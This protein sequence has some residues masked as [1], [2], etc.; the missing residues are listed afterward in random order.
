MTSSILT[1]KHGFLWRM[2]NSPLPQNNL[3]AK[4]NTLI[5]FLRP[6]S[7]IQA[8]NLIYSD[9]SSLDGCRAFWFTSRLMINSCLFICLMLNAW[10]PTWVTNNIHWDSTTFIRDE[11]VERWLNCVIEHWE[12]KMWLTL[13]DLIKTAAS[14][15]SLCRWKYVL[16]KFYPHS[17]LLC[18]LVHVAKDSLMGSELLP[19]CLCAS[20]SVS[21]PLRWRCWHGS[22][23]HPLCCP[24]LIVLWRLPWLKHNCSD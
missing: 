10:I 4:V 17:D 24:T 6:Q 1:P 21:D 12:M 2:S 23:C 20:C 8:R 15:V 3:V 19:L 13:T 5:Q 18:T 9:C 14:I 11:T 16:D 22:A 7:L